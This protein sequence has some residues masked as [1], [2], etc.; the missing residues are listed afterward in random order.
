MSYYMSM[1]KDKGKKTDWTALKKR[2]SHWAKDFWA[3]YWEIILAIV[4][5]LIIGKLILPRLLR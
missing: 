3:K 4:A 1:L 5:G 2:L